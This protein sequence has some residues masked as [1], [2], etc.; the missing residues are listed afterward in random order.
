MPRTGST[1]NA[2]RDAGHLGRPCQSVLP[3]AGGLLGV[4]FPCLHTAAHAAP[5]ALAIARS[6]GRDVE[7]GVCAPLTASAPAP[8]SKQ[9]TDGDVLITLSRQTAMVLHDDPL[10]VTARGTRRDETASLLP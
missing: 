3:L 9:A 1:A 10:G 7:Q 4:V 5:A 2:A 6:D 8:L